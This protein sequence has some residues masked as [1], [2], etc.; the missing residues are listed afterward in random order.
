MDCSYYSLPG[1]SVHEIFLAGI[2]EWVAISS[3]RG[4]SRSRDGTSVFCVSCISGG[5]FTAE[6]SGKPQIGSASLANPLPSPCHD[7]LWVEL[8]QPW[9]FMILPWL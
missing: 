6:S 8:G 4:S 9:V 1:S 7:L 5:F 3:S 2:L